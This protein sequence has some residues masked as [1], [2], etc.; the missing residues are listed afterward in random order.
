MGKDY[1]DLKKNLLQLWDRNKDDL[2]KEIK[3]HLK[4]NSALLD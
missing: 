2:M 3:F 1:I 4:V